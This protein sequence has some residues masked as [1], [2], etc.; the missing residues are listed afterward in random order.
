MSGSIIARSTERHTPASEKTTTAVTRVLLACGA[1]AGPLFFVMVTIQLLVRPGF[2]VRRHPISLLS[3]GD[4]GWI[5]I[6]T[7]IL[8]GLAGVA[9]AVGVRRAL[10]HARGGT[11][12]PLL[13]G[14][15]GL[16]LIAAGIFTADPSLGFPPGTP[17]GVPDHLSWHSVLHG[18]AFF[19]A[20]SSLTAVCFVFSRRFAGLN[21]WGWVACCAA[22]GV[23]T[24]AIVAVGVSHPS[25]AGVPF[26]A[27]AA[28]AFG[29]VSGL[30]LQLMAESGTAS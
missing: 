12:G 21:R 3:L 18:V 25:A 1:L 22:N 14:L 16:G 4:L 26:A 6:T 30:A 8:T 10:A 23:V 27:A 17:S 19:T 28:L 9:F 13:I 7:F 2:D 15:F 29:W 11:W 24:P 20:F 5:Q